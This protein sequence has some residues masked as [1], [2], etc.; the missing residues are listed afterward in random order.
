MKRKN[1][2]QWYSVILLAFGM[3][4]CQVKRPDTVI[5]DA[6]M[7]NVLYDFHIAKAMGEEVP[8]SESYKRVLYIESVYRK[9]GI[10]KA[11][12]DTSMVWYARHPDAL[13]K[14]YEKVNAR[15]KAE[16]DGI[17]HLIALRDNKPK[18][19]L[20]G[21]SVDVWIGRRIYHLSGAPLGNKLTFTLPSDTNFKDR[22]TLRWTV[23]F[24][25]LNG[26]PDSLHA[27]LMAMQVL[28]A[29]DT[30]NGMLKVKRSGTETVSLFADTLGEIKEIRGFIY[31]PAQKPVQDVLADR[32]SLMRYH[33]TDT[34][35]DAKKDSLETGG[36]AVKKDSVP[37]KSKPV[38]LKK[39]DE[40][41]ENVRRPEGRPRP[42]LRPIT[43]KK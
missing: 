30:L 7:E 6:K 11:D 21:D 19:S 28:Y 36:K 25:F 14:V 17:N 15:L 34:L 35:F 13:T 32:I 3:A 40:R 8:Y 10:T 29:K 27:P 42:H 39:P 20:P 5:P 26:T 33:A 22:D 31:Y 38:E 18:E 16:R 24:R 23:R 1:R 41:K 43:E 12:F 9:H 4:A 2:I 37:D